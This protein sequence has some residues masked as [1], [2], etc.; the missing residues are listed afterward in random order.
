MVTTNSHESR[1]QAIRAMLVDGVTQCMGEAATGK[2]CS[3]IH[4][5]AVPS[6]DGRHSIPIRFEKGALVHGEIVFLCS[7]CAIFAKKAGLDV[8]PLDE[9]ERRVLDTLGEAPAAP[10]ASP[11]VA[12]PP[13]VMPAVGR[14]PAV[15][16]DALE[17]PDVARPQAPAPRKEE[18]MLQAKRG[19][20]PRSARGHFVCLE[21]SRVFEEIFVLKTN[22]LC[23]CGACD[24]KAG[25]GF[26]TRNGDYTGARFPICPVG[27]EAALRVCSTVRRA[28][29]KPVYLIFRDEADWQR[30]DERRKYDVAR[31]AARGHAVLDGE[32]GNDANDVCAV[33]ICRA[34]KPTDRVATFD[35]VHNL[36]I[37]HR[38]C[39]RCAQSARKLSNQ[40]RE[41]GQRWAFQ[42]LREGQKL[43][44]K[45]QDDLRRAAK[46]RRKATPAAKQSTISSSAPK[47]S[48]PPAPS[49]G[50]PSFGE[51]I[52][53]AG[54]NIKAKQAE[55]AAPA[56]VA[57]ATPEPEAA[58]AAAPDSS[59]P[60]AEPTIASVSEAAPEAPA[61][62]SPQEGPMGGGAG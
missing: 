27:I 32:L 17:Q 26:A 19:P 41:G 50:K 47:G 6:F 31:D 61:P 22:N 56:A 34:P 36:F 2:V 18:P 42:L 38:I 20:H 52:A 21:S 40:L 54:R 24:V 28:G 55:D 60:A 57:S 4:G 1:R 25:K 3:R 8:L 5:T 49:A 14:V 45:Q 51:Q 9:L 23:S 13:P 37:E 11:P 48:A 30:F 12:A 16:K 7:L 53:K 44:P 43:T 46:Q 35:A 59:E 62:A 29:G 10:A 15:R 58:E 39:G 33:F